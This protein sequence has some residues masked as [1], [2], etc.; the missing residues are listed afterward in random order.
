MKKLVLSMF[1][2]AALASCVQNE[3]INPGSSIDFGAPFVGNATKAADPSY[4]ESPAQPLTAF[5]VYGTV[6]GTD[7]G[8]VNIFNGANVTGSI[9]N[10]VWDCDVTQYWIEGATYNFAAVVDADVTPGDYNMPK[11][12]S[13]QKTD[14]GFYKDMLYAFNGPIT[15]AAE[16]DSVN[17]AFEHLLAKAQFVV[18]SNTV[19]GYY[20]NVEEIKIQNIHTGAVYTIGTIEDG[21]DNGTW[22]GTLSTDVADWYSLGDIKNITAAS[23][24]NK[25][26]GDKF[27]TNATQ[28]LLIPTTETFK[29]S[30][31][32]KL[33]N[34]NGA[35]DDVLL[36]EIHYTAA[37]VA[38]CGG[39]TNANA[40]HNAPFT[41]S[42]DLVKGYAYN[43]KLD[44]TTGTEI[45][46]TVKEQ[47]TWASADSNLSL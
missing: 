21:K 46:F 23:T 7:A 28:V 29:V 13:P 27:M 36:R 16:N 30:F 6:Q 17:F 15:A 26:E 47:P 37:D 19:D 1:A 18:T 2:V 35:A 45:K 42:T 5:K 12:L 24:L 39:C 33:Y 14:K 31:V 8:V 4:G 25:T 3:T 20:Y 32:V 44:L 22:S 40:E 9:G 43:F 38:N 41:V 10:N 11:T 34:D